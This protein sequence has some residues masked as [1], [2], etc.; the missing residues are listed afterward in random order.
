M[1]SL[2]TTPVSALQ[3]S[4]GSM[5]FHIR[6]IWL[7]KKEIVRALSNNLPVVRYIHQVNSG[8]FS[9][10]DHTFAESLDHEFVDIIQDIGIPE[11]SL[12]PSKLFIRTFVDDSGKINKSSL[13]VKQWNHLASTLIQER[14]ST[15]YNIYTD[16]SKSNGQTGIGITDL[17]Y[18]NYSIGITHNI[19]ITN[20]ELAAIWKAIIVALDT[21]NSSIVIFTDSEE[22][23]RALTNGDV[24]NYLV[25][26]IW[27]LVNNHP[28]RTI[29]VQWIPGQADERAKMACYDETPLPLP[30]LTLAMWLNLKLWRNGRRNM[31]CLHV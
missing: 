24:E 18:K 23:C 2:R 27:K 14:Y 7:A 6:R 12:R 28:Q 30:F 9:S 26:A 29:T 1:R 11:I 25:H 21:D 20:A 13:T 31:I 16:A 10:K 22:G 17:R 3:V 15:S 5:P 8:L 4:A 19:Q